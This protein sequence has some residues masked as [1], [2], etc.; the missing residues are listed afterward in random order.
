MI[1][2]MK[3]GRIILA[4]SEK[5]SNRANVIGVSIGSNLGTDSKL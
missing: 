4:V 3:P 2:V 5:E 1:A